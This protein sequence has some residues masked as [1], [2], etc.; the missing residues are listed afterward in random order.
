MY[1][2]SFFDSAATADL[3]QVWPAHSNAILFR[4]QK[5][6]SHTD[7]SQRPLYGPAVASSSYLARVCT[8]TIS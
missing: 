1:I 4:T 8:V 5:F 2:F 3:K 7:I 6:F